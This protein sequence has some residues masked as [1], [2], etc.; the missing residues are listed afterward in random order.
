MKFYPIVLSLM[1]L[2]GGEAML[3]AADH[4][5]TAHADEN[6]KH[7]GHDHSAHAGEKAHADAD[8]HEGEEEGLVHLS[9]AQRKLIRIRVSKA[10][11]GEIDSTLRLPGEVRLNLEETAKVMPRIPGFVNRI[12]VKEGERV[13]KGALL[14]TLTSHKLGEYY[15]NYNSAKEQEELA[16][17]EFEMAEKLIGGNATSR[18]EYLQYKREYAEAVIACRHAEELLRSLLQGPGHDGHAHAELKSGDPVICTTYEIRSPLAGTVIAKN[19]TLGEN[20]V[21]DNTTPVFTVSNLAEPWLELRAAAADLPRLKTGMAV[22]ISDAAGGHEYH[23]KIIYVAPLID[24]TT[25]TGLV[26]VE[27]DNRDGG[28]RPGQFVTGLIRTAA[29]AKSVVVPREAVQLIAGETVVFVPKG[30]GFAAQPVVTGQGAGQEIQIVSGLKPG[31]SFVS[32]GAFELKSILLT[33][34]MDAHAGHGH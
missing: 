28:L 1:L 11:A 20:F 7:D 12:P 24:E 21:E 18:K 26:R 27:V 10:V 5:H 16:R 22:E 30:D 3:A 4:D 31:E 29:A 6:A 34:G 8:S 19:I 32:G 17:S 2:F 14:A 23:G 25:R 13:E 15:S 33:S 9:E